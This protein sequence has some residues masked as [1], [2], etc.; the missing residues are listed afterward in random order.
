MKNQSEIIVMINARWVLLF[1]V[2]AALCWAV[3]IFIIA[4]FL[5]SDGLII[6]ITVMAIL[7]LFTGYFFALE[8]KKK[9][10]RRIKNANDNQNPR[11]LPTQ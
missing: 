3:V 9:R 4:K 5:N 2:L 8:T 6:A 10:L 7:F 11:R 1:L